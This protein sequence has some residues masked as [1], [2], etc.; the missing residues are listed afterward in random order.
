MRDPLEDPRWRAR[1]AENR[2]G[3][4]APSTPVLLYHAAFDE[5]IPYTT[6]RK[7][8]D[9][10]CGLGA[11]VQWKTI[12]LAEHIVGVAVGGPIAMEWLGARFAGKPAGNSC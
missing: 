12:P 7:L 11:T 9:R 6:G 4:R 1:L 8:R 5:L 10:Y 2:A 3:A